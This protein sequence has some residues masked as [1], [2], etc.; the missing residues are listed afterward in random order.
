MTQFNSSCQKFK[1]KLLMLL[2]CIQ[3]DILKKFPLE[4]KLETQKYC[5]RSQ[6]S[7]HFTTYIIPLSNFQ[8]LSQSQAIF[9]IAIHCH[10][11][12]I[13]KYSF[14]F[15]I[16][17]CLVLSILQFDDRKKEA[18]HFDVAPFNSVVFCF[19]ICLPYTSMDIQFSI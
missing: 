15:S 4:I 11:C 6:V 2:Q 10:S 16:F 17:S 18:K 5:S 14:I 19:K 8:F 7:I 1:V 9:C 3:V 13:Y 12:L